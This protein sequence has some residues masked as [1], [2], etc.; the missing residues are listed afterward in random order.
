[1]YQN[2]NSMQPDTISQVR[3]DYPIKLFTN[4]FIETIPSASWF[5]I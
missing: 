4:F 3:K 1:M 5:Y 2:K